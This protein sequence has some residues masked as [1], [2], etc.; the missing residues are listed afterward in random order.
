MSDYEIKIKDKSKLKDTD[1][2]WKYLSL[3]VE[4]QLINESINNE[5]NK[6]GIIKQ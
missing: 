6:N 4:I 3:I 5:E 2:L 1:V